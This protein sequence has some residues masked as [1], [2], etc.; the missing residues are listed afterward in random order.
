MSAGWHYAASGQQYGP[1][2][3]Q[4]LKR[5]A[6][7]GQLLPQDL[8][9]KEGMA[10]WKPASHL[11]GLFPQTAT[12]TP[13]PLPEA[14]PNPPTGSS[15]ANFGEWYQHKFGHLAGGVQ[16]LMWLSY[17]F[18]WIPISYAVSNKKT[19][20]PKS[21]A[22]Q[23]RTDTTGMNFG[24]WYQQS[25]GR[26]PVIV[27]VFLWILYGFLWIPIWYLISTGGG[28]WIIWSYIPNLTWISWVHAA[29]RS[30]HMVYLG[31]AVLYAIPFGLFL[32]TD[33]TGNQP[34]PDWLMMLVI[35][36]WF[37]GII[38]VSINKK[39]VNYR[40][41]YAAQGESDVQIQQRVQ[42][43]AIAQGSVPAPVFSSS[44]KPGSQDPTNT[45]APSGAAPEH[46]TM[47]R[48]FMWAA[49]GLG[50]FITQKILEVLW[51]KYIG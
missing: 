47:N 49:A 33:T 51:E 9:W 40:I 5:L 14:F 21:P 19:S 42:S 32:A 6:D 17:G 44:P 31:Y 11:Q 28:G 16:V 23:V 26:L 27:Q 45:Q 1:V 34:P 35:F 20:D 50:S 36:S 8:I 29:I 39:E 22:T 7:A 15:A 4:D 30:R 13:P 10:E 46:I 25:L 12:A 43:E 3:F 41:H 2:T 48:I 38:H 18:L 24:E 37:G